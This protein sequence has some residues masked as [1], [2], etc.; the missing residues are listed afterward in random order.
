MNWQVGS[1]LKTVKL[2]LSTKLVGIVLILV[3]FKFI[4]SLNSY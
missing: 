2:A 1:N 3:I 4:L